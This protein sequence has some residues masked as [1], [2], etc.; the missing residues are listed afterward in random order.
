[1]E[2]LIEEGLK[3]GLDEFEIKELQ[4][5][6]SVGLIASILERCP[7]SLSFIKKVLEQNDKYI[8]IPELV[9]YLVYEIDNPYFDPDYGF[10]DVEGK[11]RALKELDYDYDEIK[12]EREDESFYIDEYEEMDSRPNTKPKDEHKEETISPILK[13]WLDEGKSKTPLQQKEEELSALEA[14]EKTISEAEALIEEQ[15]E[16]Q[17]KGEE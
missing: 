14:E 1:M 13:Q 11:K 10:E 7:G 4:D 8:D 9:D 5:D 16:G 15:K 6:Y 12:N 2:D 3:L 17:D